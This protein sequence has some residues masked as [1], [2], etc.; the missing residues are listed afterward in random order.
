M[1]SFARRVV[2]LTGGLIV[3]AILALPQNAFATKGREAVGMCIDST[4]S[5]NR[6]A[7]SVND[8]GEIDI[9][10]KNG[11]VYCPGADQDCKVTK[12][13]PKPTRGLP[14][15]TKVTTAVGSFTVTPRVY[16]GSLADVPA[17]KAAAYD[18]EQKSADKAPA[19]KTAGDR[20]A[21]Q[22]APAEKAP[23]DKK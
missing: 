6:C 7:W 17:D 12:S 5:G 11:C 4:A 20:A 19:D 21:A 23:A 16:T 9:C 22:K 1:G 10:N 2:F 18:A 14:V 8:K 15:G 13:R 3:A